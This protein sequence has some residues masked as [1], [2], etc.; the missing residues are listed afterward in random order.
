MAAGATLAY[1]EGPFIVNPGSVGQPRDGDPR[2]GY[3]V[4]DTE[5][6]TAT[7]LRADYDIRAAQDAIRDAGPSPAACGAARGGALT[8]PSAE[9]VGR[10]RHAASA[11]MI[12]WVEGLRDLP[13]NP[14]GVT[15]ERFG[16]T[17]A[18]ACETL[19]DLDFVN[20]VHGLDPSEA[21]RVDEVT[22]FYRRLGLRGWTEVAPVPGAE[23]TMEG[24]TSAGWAQTA[25]WCSFHGAPQALPMPAGVDVGRGDRGRDAR[26]RP[27]P[28]RRP[29]G[30]R[31]RSRGGR[32]GRASA[33]TAGRAGAC[34]WRASTASPP[35]PLHSRSTGGSA[36]WRTRRPLPAMRRRG[37][38]AALLG[39]GS[40][41]RRPR[42]ATRSRRWRSSARPA[43]ATSSG[44][45]SGWRSHRP[46]GG[47]ASDRDVRS[48]GALD[49]RSRTP[50]AAARRP[51][52]RAP[53]RSA[54]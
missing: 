2:A 7:W 43:S 50:R 45:D 54:T 20:T 22:V 12:A 36:T 40:P 52:S 17:V 33:G 39:G 14:A 9:L 26:V 13:G 5:A 6:G 18:L 35:P 38:Q 11:F 51:R 8:D 10:I 29:R 34:T 41:M 16:A 53:C 28:P 15:V 46:Y 23:T 32:S 42:A 4:L 1:G 27:R 49:A 24:L 44:P 21:G 47:C 19:P 3:V 48:G 25:F 31:R 30:A 37:C